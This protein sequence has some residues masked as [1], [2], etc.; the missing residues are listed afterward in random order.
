MLS[1]INVLFM[2]KILYFFWLLPLYIIVNFML[3]LLL[4]LFIFKIIS[5]TALFII[6]LYFFLLYGKLKWSFFSIIISSQKGTI[7]IYF[8][9]CTFLR[10]FLNNY[11]AV[12]IIVFYNIIE[13]F[14]ITSNNFHLVPHLRLAGN[15]FRMIIRVWFIFLILMI[16]NNLSLIQTIYLNLLSLEIFL[17]IKIEQLWCIN[18]GTYLFWIINWAG[19]KYVLI[20]IWQ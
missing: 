13:Q 15:R 4:A 12:Y 1:W 7:F 5:F 6:F 3:S 17:R 16:F 11:S 20:S 2:T 9:I 19:I 8:L 18:I 14:I 10:L